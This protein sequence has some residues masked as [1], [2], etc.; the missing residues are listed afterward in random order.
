[1][2][3]QIIV[4]LSGKLVWKDKEYRCAL[5]RGGI[6]DNKKEGD[7]A[8]PAGSFPLREVYYRADRAIEPETIFP[9]H[10]ISENDGWCDD[11]SDSNYN[12]FVKLPHTARHEK[13]WREDNIYDVIVVVGYNDDPPIPGKGSAI[14]IHV[15]R[16]ELTP[17]DGCIALAEEDLLEILK[18]VDQE[19][20]ISIGS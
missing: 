12:R 16:P 17:T 18:T 9:T 2:D 6:L 19:T 8:T 3:N 14:F 15:A 7:G 1:M 11:P 4:Y 10:A 13:L 20:L 5:G